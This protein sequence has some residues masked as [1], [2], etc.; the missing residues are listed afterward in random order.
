MVLSGKGGT[1]KTSVAASLAALS[2]PCVLADCDVD[3]ADMHLLTQP[4]Q[5]ERHDFVSGVEA[6]IDHDRCTNCGMCFTFCR[7]EAIRPAENGTFDIDPLACEGCGVCA[8]FCP[9]DAIPLTPRRCGAWFISGTPYGPMAHAKL[10]VA[11]ENSGR[12]VSVVRNTARRLAEEHQLP[13]IIGD[14]PPGIG[15]PAIA[16]ITGATS[17]LVVTE[18][19]VSGLH[20]LRRILD[21]AHHFGISPKVCVN[22][23]NLNPGMTEKME[24][25]ASN[26]GAK[27]VGRI[28]YDPSFTRSQ[29]E[30]RPL[31]ETDSPAAEEVCALWQALELPRSIDLDNASA[32]TA[33]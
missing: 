18:P 10:G 6:V 2:G 27:P 5:M 17:V 8:R 21:L 33:G 22:K 20:D 16:S 28:S 26:L 15:C 31:V 19:T 11:A 29:L 3:A 9:N 7:F 4:K 32:A 24:E 14:G 30:A 1:G 25:Q 12:L 13:L 23:W